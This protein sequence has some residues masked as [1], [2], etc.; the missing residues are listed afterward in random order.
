MP[1]PKQ[2]SLH[3]ANA[4]FR[5]R[6]AKIPIYRSDDEKHFQASLKIKDSQLQ[7]KDQIIDRLI[8]ILDQYATNT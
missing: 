4:P 7:R 3:H 1:L 2:V 6:Y 5:L 8:P